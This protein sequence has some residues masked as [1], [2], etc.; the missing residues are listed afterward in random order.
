MLLIW[1]WIS[2]M[3]TGL[4]FIWTIH[5]ILY[6]AYYKTRMPLVNVMERIIL[7]ADGRSVHK[8]ISVF[9]RSGFASSSSHE[10]LIVAYCKWLEFG[11]HPWIRNTIL[12]KLRPVLVI[13]STSVAPEVISHALLMSQGFITFCLH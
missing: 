5:I 12:P 11:P 3:T 9:L 10:S 6:E 13:V 7:Q 8:K 2:V 1:L 4:W